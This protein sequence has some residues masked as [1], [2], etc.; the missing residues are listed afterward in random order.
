MLAGYVAVTV[1]AAMA[2]ACAAVSA[3]AHIR[4]RDYR[5]LA[6]VNWAAFFSLAVAALVVGL[7]YHGP[8]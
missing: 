1:V 7:A 2:Y 3:G 4:A 5:L 6:W 8:W